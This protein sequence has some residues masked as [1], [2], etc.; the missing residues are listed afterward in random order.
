MEIQD[1]ESTLPVKKVMPH[2]NTP[3]D[4]R[5]MSIPIKADQVRKRR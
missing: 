1:I 3:K 4:Y 5:K 2:K